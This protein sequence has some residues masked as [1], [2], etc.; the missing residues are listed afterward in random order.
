MTDYLATLQNDQTCDKCGKTI[1]AGNK[2][3]KAPPTKQSVKPRFF[4][5]DCR[6]TKGGRHGRR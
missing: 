4:H 3:I 6:A 5:E 2:A 1:E